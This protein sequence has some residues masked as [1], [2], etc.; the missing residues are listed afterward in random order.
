MIRNA[1][2]LPTLLVEN[3]LKL[4]V[5]VLA[6]LAPKMLLKKYD[7]CIIL[8]NIFATAH[9]SWLVLRFLAK[10]TRVMPQIHQT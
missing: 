9:I 2:R 10:I 7:L 6:K 4:I 1:S 8:T 3:L 5:T